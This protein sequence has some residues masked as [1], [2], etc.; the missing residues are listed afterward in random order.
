MSPP[1]SRLQRR[2]P[3]AALVTVSI[4]AVATA[5]AAPEAPNGHRNHQ[6]PADAI[7][8]IVPPSARDAY[9]GLLHRFS[10]KYGFAIRIAQTTP[11]G[12]DFLVQMFR[13]DIKVI[14][15]NALTRDK[16]SLYFFATCDEE[17]DAITRGDIAVMVA[18]LRAMLSKTKGL[19]IEPLKSG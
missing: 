10:D 11:S 4:L 12:E 13:E 15:T 18:D 17:A 6:A 14:S 8:V 3:L 16:F 2:A 5:A 19:A 1:S 9:F 7:A